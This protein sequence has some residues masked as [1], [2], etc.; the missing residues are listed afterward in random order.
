MII[1][2]LLKKILINLQY[3]N[4]AGEKDIFLF[5][6]SLFLSKKGFEII[7]RCHDESKIIFPLFHDDENISQ[8]CK[9]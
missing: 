8:W 4:S 5:Q 7:K 2:F 3:S 6:A 1:I 9:Q